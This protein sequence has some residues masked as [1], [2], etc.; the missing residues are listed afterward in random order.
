MDFV[1]KYW[2]FD[3]WM[4]VLVL[5][6]SNIKQQILMQNV[7]F[8]HFKQKS[9][10]SD[11]CFARV[12]KIMLKLAHIHYSYLTAVRG[13]SHAHGVFFGPS[14]RVR[15]ETHGKGGVT[16]MGHGIYFL[17]CIR[18]WEVSFC[19]F[20]WGGGGVYKKLPSVSFF[21][22][23]WACWKLSDRLRQHNIHVWLSS[24]TDLNHNAFSTNR[25]D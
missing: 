23:C 9:N 14:M 22:R 21:K 6:I 4:I 3:G 16:G 12:D 18:R 20:L 17:T 19:A 13:Q 15:R 10:I 5:S 8:L 1:G 25:T 11:A 7:E 24:P 2:K